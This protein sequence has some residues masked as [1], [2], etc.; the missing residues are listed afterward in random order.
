M[1][2]TNKK[3]NLFSNINSI[4]GVGRKISSYLKKK[5]IEKVND[6]L[7]DLPYDLTF[8]SESTPLDK[9]EIGKIFTINV[10]VV[11][12]NFPRIRNLP[13]KIICKDDFGEIDLIFFN[14]REGYIKTI[15]P[16]NE[17]VVVSGKVNYF[18]NKYQMTNPKYLSKRENID[19][20]KKIIPKY[21]LTEGLKEITYRN[22]IEK[23]INQIP[24]IEEWHEKNFIKKMGF[25]SWKNSI[26]NLHNPNSEKDLNS[27]F[28]KR[29]AYDEIFANLLFLSN[30]RNKIK[31]VKKDI[32]KFIGTYSVQLIKS[33]PYNL[34][35]GQKK[36]IDEINSDLKS[37]SRMFRILQG[38]VG[39]GKTIVAIIAG[40]NCIE[41][42]Y[43]CSL[44]APTGILA[45]Q[46]FKML[47]EIIVY[48]NL[49]IKIEVL[50]GRTDIKKRKII[51][52][53]LENKKIDFLIGTHALFQE[54]ISFNKLGLIIIDEQHK[55][56]VRQRIKFAKKGGSN[57]DVLLMSAT[58]IPRTM[59]MSI[60]GDMD[61]SR[62]EE[63]PALRQKIL[64]LSKPE[65]KIDELWPFLEKKIKTNEQIFWICPLI[66]ESKKLDF[67]STTKTF[68][69]VSKKF[70]RKVGFIHGNL[71][72][73]EK[74]R[75]LKKFLDNEISILVS[76]TV[77]EV[78]IDF[79]NATVIIIEN[80]NK[81]G[82]AQL[83]QLRGRIG[84]SDKAGTCILFF[85]NQLSQ[86]AKKRI[87]ILK[88]SDDGFYIAE[89]D[90]KLR[91]YGDIIGFKQ[92]G[93]KLFKIADPVHHEN[94]FSLAE[95][96]I[97]KLNI[98]EFNDSKYEFLLK[99]FDKVDLIDEEK[100]SS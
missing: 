30:N 44:M 49:K 50:T 25:S 46:H 58:P 41:A 70:P 34:T 35:N 8:R 52:N 93:Q 42:G 62:L 1:N 88:S 59:M 79:P 94:L 73:D 60:Y 9:L 84:R 2:F 65:N 51:L 77:I 76:T 15:L 74:E 23:V 66:E 11:K 90:M 39:S 54:T 99:L 72:Q 47:N 43:Q 85:K 87:Q 38:D 16:L 22:V 45:E 67:S 4:Q 21:S 89:E 26:I 97:N 29:I 63:K 17:W 13:N 32:K 7:W 5:G 96:N 71:N 31:K 55:F 83:H 28:L 92:S 10:Q 69:L 95:K 14:S 100:V 98:N 33:L 20:I 61:T 19:K 86:N 56:G 91:G 64:T 37:Q 27:I 81:F 18:G 78:G 48:S 3:F 6:L 57:C 75:V 53:D 12:Y 80:S 40:L 82:L 36:V 24:D 68:Q